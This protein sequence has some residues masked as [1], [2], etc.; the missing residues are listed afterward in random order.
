M[1]SL[2]RKSSGRIE[3]APGAHDDCVMSYLIAL[4]TLKYGHNLRRYGIIR[5]LRKEAVEELQRAEEKD[6]PMAM[7]EAMPDS[8]KKMFPKPGSQSLVSS[9][10][11]DV[12]GMSQSTLNEIRQADPGTPTAYDQIYRNIESA[13]AR[14][15]RH[16]TSI[17]P[18][19]KIDIDAEYIEDMIRQA[20]DKDAS[21][22]TDF[23]FDVS[24]LLNK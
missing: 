11:P 12:G 16:R 8:F 2:I 18:N 4:Y 3:A 1:N 5:G 13:Q 7:W 6:D 20:S 9:V 21:D 14:R 10:S 23:A 24:D 17:D 22:Y 19:A 15:A